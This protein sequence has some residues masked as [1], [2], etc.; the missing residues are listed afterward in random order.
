MSQDLNHEEINKITN[1]IIKGQRPVYYLITEEKLSDMV[2]NSFVSSIFFAIFSIFEGAALKDKNGVYAAIGI[3]FLLTSIYFYWLKIKFIRKT[4]KSGEVQYVKFDAASTRDGKLEIIKAIYGT[5]PDKIMDITS[6]LNN[7]ISDNK[8]AFTLLNDI[9]GGDPDKGVNKTL[10]IEYRIGS[11]II[12]K[13][14]KE[15]E[16]INL[17]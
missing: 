14:Y 15:Y 11:E 1:P 6:T 7:K 12:R 10:D 8:L 2:T 4:K 3:I 13:K 9:V 5:P 16:N 17:P